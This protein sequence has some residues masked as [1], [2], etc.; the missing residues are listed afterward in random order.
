MR[1]VCGAGKEGGDAF[2][3]RLVRVEEPAMCT[4]EVEVES[5]V[6]CDERWARENGIEVAAGGGH[7][8]L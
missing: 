7:E 8:E 2:M 6:G 4:Y 3:H 1:V 5:P